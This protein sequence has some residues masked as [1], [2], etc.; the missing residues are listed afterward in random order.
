MSSNTSDKPTIELWYCKINST[1]LES[2]RYEVHFIEPYVDSDGTTLISVLCSPDKVTIDRYYLLAVDGKFY[3]HR[4]DGP[5]VIGGIIAGG[6]GGAAVWYKKGHR[7][8]E[9]GPARENTSLWPPQYYL[10][11]IEY[12]KEDFHKEIARRKSLSAYPELKPLYS[13]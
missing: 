1:I 11:N 7:H 6:P 9:G 5:A 2:R 12:A 8:R 13:V 3:I 4:L 10:D